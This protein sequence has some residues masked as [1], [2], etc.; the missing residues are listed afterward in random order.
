MIPKV[1]VYGSWS[2]PSEGGPN[3]LKLL[4]FSAFHVNHALGSAQLLLD[5]R[6]V[7]SESDFESSL[8]AEVTLE[9]G[10]C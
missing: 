4:H 7:L 9:V 10:F 3:F 8:A 1:V 5:V 2:F 6:Q